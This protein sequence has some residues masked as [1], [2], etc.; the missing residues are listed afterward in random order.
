MTSAVIVVADEALCL[1]AQGWASVGFL[2]ESLWLDRSVVRQG[3]SRSEWQVVEA[4]LLD[5]RPSHPV[6]LQHFLAD[7]DHLDEVTVAWVR[8]SEDDDRGGMD[9]LAAFIRRLIN[10]SITPA[11]RDVIVPTS[12]DALTT[13]A[14]VNPWVQVVVAPEDHADLDSADAGWVGRE[15]ATTLH[16]VA[17]LVGRLGG[18]HAAPGPPRSP[19]RQ[20][21][22]CVSRIVVGAEQA[23]ARAAHYLD[24]SLPTFTACDV[25]P[26]FHEYLADQG[27]E[28]ERAV[29]HV[30]SVAEGCLDYLAKPPLQPSAITAFPE[31]RPEPPTP[32]HPWRRTVREFLTG[33]DPYEDAWARTD[34]DGNPL[35]PRGWEQRMVP[36]AQALLGAAANDPGTIPPPAVWASLIRL[37]TS[38]ADGGQP[39]DGYEPVVTH[40]R[41]GVVSL[42]R[43]MPGAFPDDAA[44]TAEQRTT[45][46]ELAHR[47][48]PALVA[49][50]TD[51]VLVELAARTRPIGADGCGRAVSALAAHLNDTDDTQQAQQAEQLRSLRSEGSPNTSGQEP[52]PFFDRVLQLILTNS[53]RARLVSQRLHALAVAEWPQ[54]RWTTGRVRAFTGALSAIALLGLGLWAAFYDDFDEWMASQGNDAPPAALV[55]AALLALLVLS[56]IGGYLT[57]LR[58]IRERDSYW[59]WRMRARIG[60]TD[61]A[62]AAYGEHARLEN[63]LRIVSLWRTIVAGIL[64]N[65]QS[66]AEH[67]QPHVPPGLPYAL[68]WVRPRLHQPYQQLVEHGA[69]AEPGF[70]QTILEAV[71]DHVLSQY[72]DVEVT[73]PFLALCEDTGYREGDLDRVARDLAGSWEAWRAKEVERIAGKVRAAIA[74]ADTPVAREGS[75]D[76]TEL[77]AYLSEI[78]GQVTFTPGLA[79]AEKDHSGDTITFHR[80]NTVGAGQPPGERAY[81]SAG[82]LVMRIQGRWTMTNHP[83]GHGTGDVEPATPSDDGLEQ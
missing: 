43:V 39:P 55:G 41:R 78:D 57:T 50:S 11:W 26:R 22:T 24:E 75:A 51:A 66:P 74:V 19:G 10:T 23:Q 73:G 21:A 1:L 27:A 32:P 25:R 6:S 62:V 30:M 3:L 53:I 14:P 63:A 59:R 64:P 82:V 58:V 80:W 71:A 54:P 18:P 60:L 16:V 9:S 2:A 13:P 76:R 65:A 48:P 38:L 46:P 5:H 8:G 7:E 33:R 52:T 12:L 36:E 45:M 35:H 29:A 28:V 69:G 37:T 44:W 68:G 72:H 34:Q 70:R 42:A 31:T 4:Q 61:R 49:A 83:S 47:L 15:D 67:P 77:A 17:A 79:V 40:G 20:I 81:A 56:L